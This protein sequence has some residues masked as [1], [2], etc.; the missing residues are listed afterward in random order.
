M[1]NSG[2]NL[3]GAPE[4]VGN[5]VNGAALILGVTLAVRLG[6]RRDT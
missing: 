3:A 1:P 5:Y 6:G 4:Y 2:L